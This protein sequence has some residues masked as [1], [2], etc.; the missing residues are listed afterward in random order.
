VSWDNDGAEQSSHVGRIVT[1]LSN[2]PGAMA[3]LTTA[4]A[5]GHGN[6]SNLKITDRSAD[7]FEIM[8]DIEVRNVRHLTNIIAALR[9]NPTVNS[10]ERARG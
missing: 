1:V 5:K 4:I 3:A 10:V 7:F 9:A 6:I 2:Q 8:V